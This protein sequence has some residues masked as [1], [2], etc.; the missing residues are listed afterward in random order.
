MI[1]MQEHPTEYTQL[2]LLSKKIQIIE[3]NIK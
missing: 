3:Q 1:L 2:E